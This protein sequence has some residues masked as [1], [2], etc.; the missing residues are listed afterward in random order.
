M[1]QEV[2]GCLKVTT[3]WARVQESPGS[4]ARFRHRAPSQLLQWEWYLRTLLRTAASG[5]PIP[6]GLA[7]GW[8]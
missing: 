3:S 1:D 7:R 2:L 4:L 5:H 8:S 6:W